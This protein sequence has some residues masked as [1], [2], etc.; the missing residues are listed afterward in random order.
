VK[1]R[2]N[3]PPRS[4]EAARSRESRDL[5]AWRFDVGGDQYALLVWPEPRAADGF[6]G[7]LTAAEREVARLMATGFSNADIARRRGSSPRTVANQAASIFRKLGVRSR[8]ELNA[9][10]SRGVNRDPA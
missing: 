6:S 8:L 5:V 2:D 10:V 7:R 1:D 9:L 3:S 4:G